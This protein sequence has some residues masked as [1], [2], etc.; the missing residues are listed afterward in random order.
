MH[1]LWVA[2]GE[3]GMGEVVGGVVGHAELL[4]DALRPQIRNGR[5]RD[6]LAETD[7]VERVVERSL[8]AFGRVPATPVLV[9]QAPTDLDRRREMRLP[10]LRREA[11]VPGELAGVDDLDRPQP[12][13]VLGKPS[14]DAVDERV[15]LRARQRR[16]VVLHHGGI[17]VHCREQRAILVPPRAQPQPLRT[18]IVDHKCLSVCIHFRS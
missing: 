2:F 18:Q 4:H 17:R 12:P 10:R 5:E 6:H 7:D 14:F 1:A 16:R 11:D 13:P 9:R 8:T 15:A 3:R